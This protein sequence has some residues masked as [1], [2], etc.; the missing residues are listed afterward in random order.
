MPSTGLHI[1]VD[2]AAVDWQETSAPGVHWSLLSSA[3]GAGGGASAGGS[4]LIR[5]APGHGYPPHRHL[6][7]EEVLVLAGG[8]SDD[9]G[10]YRAGDYVGYEPGSVHAPVAL[11]DSSRATGPDNPACVLFA[12][13]SGGIE[14]L[15]GPSEP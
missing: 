7:P 5:M 12:S 6:G 4:V 2:E 3:G 8:Y 13:A 1:R 14:V 15:S 11:G 9:R 10:T